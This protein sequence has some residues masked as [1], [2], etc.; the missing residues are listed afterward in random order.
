MPTK[1]EAIK[2]FLIARTHS[3]LAN[4]YNY[5]MEVQVNVRKGSGERASSESFRGRTSH[6]YTDG[7][8]KWYSF[9][10]PRKAFSEP[11]YIDTDIKYDLDIHAEGIGMTGW[12]WKER[13]SKWVGFDFDDI[14]GHATGLTQPELD[15]VKK[16]ATSIPWITVRRSTSGNGLHLYV[17]LNNVPTVTH[18][19]H[20]ALGRSILG[21]LSAIA[22]FDFE[23]KVDV[24]GGNLWIWH[25]KMT[26]QG[27]GLELIK[28]GVAL[29]EIP[30]NWKDHVL[31]IKGKRRKSLPRYI[32]DERSF[33]DAN[34]SRKKVKLDEQHKKLLDFLEK[35]ESQWWYDQ[36][37]QM[38]VCHTYDLK[39][40]HKE[41]KLRGIFDTKATG[42]YRGAD[43]NCFSGD[44]EILTKE[45]P[46][47]IKDVA[48]KGG[49]YLYVAT[50]EGMVWRWSKV[51][52]FGEQETVPITLGQ[53]HPLRVT[54]NHDWF[55]CNTGRYTVDHRYKKKTYE[56]R[57]NSELLPLAPIELPEIDWEGYAHGFVFGD[58]WQVNV[59][60]KLSCNVPFFKNDKDL[61][62]LL[63]KYGNIGDALVP[64]HGDVPTARQLPEE[65]KHLPNNPTKGYALGFLLGLISADGHID[66]E[67]RLVVGQSDWYYMVEI[68]NLAIYA[69]LSPYELQ[70]IERTSGF[71]G[72]SMVRMCISTYN[73]TKEHFLRKDQQKRFK[74]SK[75]LTR[76][77]GNIDFDDKIKEEVF[78]A[79][80]PTYHN[81][82]LADGVITGNC[83]LVPLSEPEGS[84]VVR[85]YTQGIEETSGWEPDCH[86]WTT[87]Y[88]NRDLT[89]DISAKVHNGAEDEK[90][91]FHF[92]CASDAEHVVEDLGLKFTLPDWAKGRPAQ[93]K[94]TKDGRLLTQIKRE[95]LDPAIQGWVEDKGYW[96]KVSK[97]NLHQPGERNNEDYD[98][99]IR[100]LVTQEKVD[101]GWAIKVDTDSWVIEPLPHVRLAL[102]N[103]GASPREISDILGGA[104]LDHWTL[105]NE[106]FQ[107]EFPGGRKWNRKAAQ[108]AYEPKKERPFRYPMWKKVL[109]H[110]GKGLDLTVSEDTWCRD[111]GI[112]TGADY[113][114]IWAASI[115]QFP[116][117]R[118][119]YLFFY[120]KEENTGKT[121]FHESLGM[122]LTRG[123]IRIDH[124]LIS[125]SGFN[126]E[127]ENGI[128]CAVEETDLGKNRNARNRIKDW[129]T[130]SRMTIH[131]KGKTPY[132][133]ENCTHI[134]QTGNNHTECPI[135]TGDTR[136]TMIHV[137]P[138]EPNELIDS[139]ELQAKLKQEAP[140]FLGELLQV[141]IPPSGNRLNVPVLDTEIK[142]QTSEGNK[143][144]VEV[145]LDEKVH[146]APGE[147]IKYGELYRLFETCVDPSDG[148]Y[149]GKRK[150]GQQ[151]PHEYPKGPSPKHSNQTIVGNVSLE[152]PET[153]ES[154]QIY[155]L[156][157]GKV[158]LTERK[159]D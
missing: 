29:E 114:K 20:A 96:K 124:S 100:H 9:R 38:V 117:K 84:W 51:R 93:L 72:K 45:G 99:R 86:G 6:S 75:R 112:R 32:E 102:Q 136:I 80:V 157:G 106:P 23:S 79:I 88:Y 76:T 148:H 30:Q 55:I 91:F 48:V 44:T 21:K 62:R 63:S 153:T 11:E 16:Q 31:V 74:T 139:Y 70:I 12:D 127:M 105:I 142:E 158:V 73:L 92:Q 1:T 8:Q 61:I 110:C 123:Y 95:P 17:F 143:N 115:F 159:N 43:H 34:N 129:V 59:Q 64:G 121:T 131:R 140:D 37:R 65:W 156:R 97:A 67:G 116:K 149:W 49:A 60:G 25:R 134:V 132:E 10:I 83:F 22:G 33:D 94:E 103:V 113:L 3:D 107:P 89:L 147:C 57:Q 154:T 18:T 146:Y 137:P 151:L 119:P 141:D 118:L 4:M 28:Q 2:N 24:A 155:I 50:P 101:Q 81:F 69:G 19:E 109:G 13:V 5:N 52:S 108:Y 66:R 138:F 87:C 47:K 104:V 27:H 68:R 145:F 77:V 54:L 35:S 98:N 7:V 39:L 85:R 46:C 58:G 133:T 42:Q 130:T 41:L 90:G 125:N 120:S 122:L 82:T 15:E 135:F 150:F 126:G 128:L 71:P 111:N 56:L 14:S 40:A 144:A 36:D 152:K 78:C 26:P 53:F